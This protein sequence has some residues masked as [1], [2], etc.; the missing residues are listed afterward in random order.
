[1]RQNHRAFFCHR[2]AVLKM[3]AAASVGGYCR[4]LVVQYAGAGLAKIYH[5]FNCEN[6]AFPQ[7]G[8]LPAGSEVGH[9]RLFVEPGS[10]AVSHEL[11][12]HTET[13]SLYKFLDR[14]AHIAD[15][16]ADPRLLDALVQRSF[17]DLEQLCALPA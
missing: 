6:H 5:R 8:A 17:R 4:P 2:H 10:D 11:A 16:I 1:M 13:V 7:P 9:L 3:R 15:R 14:C 12:H